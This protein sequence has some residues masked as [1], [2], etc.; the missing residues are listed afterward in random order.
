MDTFDHK[1]AD[2]VGLQESLRKKQ[3]KEAC[4]FYEKIQEL[5]GLSGQITKCGT[6]IEKST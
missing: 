1:E 2:L 6:L 5:Q 4:F 3:I